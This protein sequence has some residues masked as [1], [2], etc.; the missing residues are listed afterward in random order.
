MIT[1]LIH[2]GLASINTL[3]L[4]SLWPGTAASQPAHEAAL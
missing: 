3:E 4:T 2:S 1:Y